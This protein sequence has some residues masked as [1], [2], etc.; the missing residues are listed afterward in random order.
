MLQAE[1]FMDDGTPIV[2]TVTIDPDQGNAVFDFT[3]TGPQSEGNCNT[4]RA[5]VQSAVLY[6]L[7]CMV[8]YDVPLNQVGMVVGGC[9]YGRCLVH[10]TMYAQGCLAPVRLVIPDGTLLSPSDEAAVIG[11][12]VLTSQRITD[13]VFKAFSTCAASQVCPHHH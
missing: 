2:L 6:C 4:P 5:V 1:D 10:V 13:V 8:G 9:G 3:G 7:R 12:N 11:G